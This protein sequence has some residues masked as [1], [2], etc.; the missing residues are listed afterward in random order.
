MESN[1]QGGDAAAAKRADVHPPR[2][3]SYWLALDAR[4]NQDEIGK[5]HKQLTEPYWTCKFPARVWRPHERQCH[6]VP[7]ENSTI[8]SHQNMN[9]NSIEVALHE[10][11]IVAQQIKKIYIF[12]TAEVSIPC[13]QGFGVR[14]ALYHSNPVTNIKPPPPFFKKKRSAY[15]ILVGIPEGKNHLEDLGIDGRIILK[16]ILKT[17]G[18]DLAQDRNK[19]LAPMT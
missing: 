12:Y 5:A 13:L 10:R 11:L 14:T 7:Q 3:T 19:W 1:G 4:A 9:I 6:A 16:L 2:F 18:V 17:L 8:V 15:S